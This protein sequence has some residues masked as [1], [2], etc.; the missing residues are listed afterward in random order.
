MRRYAT[1]RAAKLTFRIYPSTQGPMET[2]MKQGD[3]V[4]IIGRDGFY[5]FLKEVQGMAT[6]REGSAKS[7]GAPT[8][9]IPMG[10]VVS[11]EKAE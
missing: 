10:R 5:L 3:F 7:S 6:L 8:F 9:A 11:L 2:E 4:K 1:T